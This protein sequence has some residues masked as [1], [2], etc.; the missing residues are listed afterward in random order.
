MRLNVLQGWSI[1]LLLADTTHAFAAQDFPLAS[2]A[3]W[4]ATVTSQTGV[5]TARAIMHGIVTKEDIIEY[6]NRDPG[7][8]TRQHGGSLTVNQCVGSNSK[9]AG[10]AEYIS[11]ANCQMDVLVLRRRGEPQRKVVL[12]LGD[13]ADTSCASGLPPLIAEFKILCPIA[14]R[15]IHLD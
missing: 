1:V 15:R 4:G 2:C 9:L 11:E 8:E 14:A 5:N 6:C 12:P 13:N 10:E 3:G 7:G